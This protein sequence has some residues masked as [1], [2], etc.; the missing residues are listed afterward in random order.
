MNRNSAVDIAKY[1]AA[2]FVV[3]IHTHP[4]RDMSELADFISVGLLC[5]WAVPFF[6]IC[7]G[8]Y[9]ALATANNE[10]W[11]IIGK[12]FYKILKMYVGWSLFFLM[13]YLVDWYNEGT[14]CR[15]Y[16]VGW[17]MSLF[18]SKTYYHLWYLSALLYALPL[19]AL[20][21][22]LIPLR[23]F[24]LLQFVCGLFK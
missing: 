20:L 22:R 19:F 9:L 1:I 3:A 8:F 16:I 21:L 6:A 7:T 4:L 14:L 18:V 2:I 17:L 15:E 11:S 12:S 10:K 13:I 24:L 23:L 5:P